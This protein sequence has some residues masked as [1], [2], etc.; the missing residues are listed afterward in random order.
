MKAEVERPDDD[1]AHV[2]EKL[3]TLREQHLNDLQLLYRMQAGDYKIE[4]M[5]RYLSKDDG[6]EGDG[7]NLSPAELRLQEIYS[8][9]VK[10]Q[11]FKLEWQADYERA[12]YAY[13]SQLIALTGQRRDIEL[14]EE[15]A[16]KRREQMF[17]LSIPDFKSKGKDVQLRAARFLVADQANQQKFMEKFGWAWRQVKPLRDIFLVEEAFAADVRAMV[18]SEQSVRDPRKARLA[19]T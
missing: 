11:A 12:R 18:L 5:D 8:D 15:E 2:K 3:K 6:Q 7:Q 10:D 17:P 13:L 9:A 4:A 19:A 14:R 16:R 1:L